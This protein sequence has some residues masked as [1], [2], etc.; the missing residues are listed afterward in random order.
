ME[1]SFKV[2]TFA[3]EKWFDECEL[4]SFYTVHWENNDDSETDRFFMKYE[5]PEKP[6]SFEA[7]VL[8]RLITHSIG[9][10]YGAIDD[11][12]DRTKNKAQALPPKPKHRIPDIYEI[13]INFPLR[14]YCFRISNSIVVLFNG[15]IKNESTDQKSKDISLKFYEAQNFANRISQALQDGTIVIQK[16]N[17]TLTDFQGNSPIIL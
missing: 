15:G 8:L 2:N 7:N 1:I 13:G 14:L 6:Y 12:F 4:C 9:N 17:R 10:R 3:V 16:D 11:F 5:G